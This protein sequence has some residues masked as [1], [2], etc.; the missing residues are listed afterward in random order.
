MEGIIS[1]G[2]V[3]AYIKLYLYSYLPASPNAH[4]PLLPSFFPSSPPFALPLSLS[5]VKWLLKTDLTFSSRLHLQSA[6]VPSLFY[7]S[8]D[9]F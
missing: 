1:H 4:P 3:F 2:C 5:H 6:R 9:L 7:H 8:R